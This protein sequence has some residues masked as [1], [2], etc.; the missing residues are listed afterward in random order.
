MSD[1]NKFLMKLYAVIFIFILIGVGI[2]IYHKEILYKDI[3]GAV[4]SKKWLEAKNKLDKLGKYR[5]SE[6]L[7]KKVNYHYYLKIA[8]ELYNKKDYK[9]AFQ[10]YQKSLKANADDDYLKNQIAKT[11][12]IIKKQEQAEKQKRLEKEK[13]IKLEQEK[14]EKQKI[15]ERKRN[16]AK[17]E[18]A[19]KR[20]FYKIDFWGD[21]TTKIYDYYVEPALWYQWNFDVKEGAFKLAV[22]YAKL[23]T[24]EQ[25]DDV[26]Y[27]IG[28]KIRSSSDKSIL[29]EY[30]ALSHNIKIK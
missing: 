20:T 12:M 5:N 6:I 1:D 27:L 18:P 22:L 24:N 9:L 19:I 15:I 3:Q 11:E 28:T 23:K 13:K 29:A 21:N 10:N 26:H 17:I 16:L 25:Y 4:E 8:D 7:M 2:G 14:L 30:S